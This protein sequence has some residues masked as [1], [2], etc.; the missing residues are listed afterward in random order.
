MFLNGIWSC[1]LSEFS[2]A[3]HS[4]TFLESF[5]TSTDFNCFFIFTKQN[6]S[7]KAQALPKSIFW[8]YLSPHL[9]FNFRMEWTFLVMGICSIQCLQLNFG[10][11]WKENRRKCWSLLTYL[12]LSL[13]VV[14]NV[15]HNL[16]YFP[17]LFEGLYCLL[18]FA[19]V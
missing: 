9:N 19:P 12:L 14:N 3:F 15:S 11:F 13:S 8:R 1:L 17:H 2:F 10:T 7:L 4:F 6:P 5:A 18:T 16:F